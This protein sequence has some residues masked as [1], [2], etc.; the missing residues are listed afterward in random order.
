MTPPLLNLTAAAERI[1]MSREWLRKQVT[2]EL[3]PCHRFG[4]EV[5][6][7]EEQIAQIIADHF[8][9]VKPRLSLVPRAAQSPGPTQPPTQP[10]RPSGPT[11]PPKAA[12]PKMRT[13]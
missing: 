11:P 8:Q 9:P 1:G 10:P 6:F 7:T 2:A 4:R 3:V 13:A 5:R 12:N